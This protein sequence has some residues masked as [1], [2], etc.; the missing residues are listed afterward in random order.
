[1]VSHRPFFEPKEPRYHPE[2]PSAQRARRLRAEL[3]ESASV[4]AAIYDAGFNSNSR[5][6]EASQQLLGMAP[7]AYRAGGANAR[8]RFA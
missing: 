2:I 1:M 6:Y 4:T 3:G 7:R 5:F 8:I